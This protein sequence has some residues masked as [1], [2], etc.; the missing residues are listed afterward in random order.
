MSPYIFCITSGTCVCVF[1][2]TVCSTDV[3]FVLD[4]SGSIG[5][6]QFRSTREFVSV[7]VHSLDVGGS[8]RVGAVSYSDDHLHAFHLNRYQDK[9]LYHSKP[10]HFIAYHL[11]RHQEEVIYACTILL[12][13]HQIDCMKNGVWHHI[14]Y[15]NAS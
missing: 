5:S 2:G 13:V 3:V 14:M 9:V 11:N 6:K 12:N 8:S 10:R 7:L 15:L 4:F 1:L